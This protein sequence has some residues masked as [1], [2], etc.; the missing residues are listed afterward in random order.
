MQGSQFR[1][2]DGWLNDPL[3]GILGPFMNQTIP[4]AFLPQGVQYLGNITQLTGTGGYNALAEVPT[5]NLPVPFIVKIA[6][7]GDQDYQLQSGVI[8]GPGTVA[9][10]DQAQSNKT[11]VSIS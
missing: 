5:V 9:P 10:N 4:P 1:N 7:T 6:V 2:K 8:T 3:S 11:W